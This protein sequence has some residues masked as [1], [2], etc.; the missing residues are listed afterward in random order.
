[1]KNYGKV[2]SSAQPS[3]IEFTETKVFVASNI[4]AFTQNLGGYE[5]NGYVYD[6]IEYNKDEYIQLLSQQSQ[7]LEEEL[8]ATKIL[9]G[10]D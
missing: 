7:R 10:V 8:A 4:E 1:M 3:E 5:E 9:L 6:Y 2:Q